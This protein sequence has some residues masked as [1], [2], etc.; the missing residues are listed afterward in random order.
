MNSMSCGKP[1]PEDKDLLCTLAKHRD[2]F[3]FLVRLGEKA[4]YH[5]ILNNFVFFN[6]V[7]R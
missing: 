7:S 5:V 2:N 3:Q 6:P 4:L 1:L